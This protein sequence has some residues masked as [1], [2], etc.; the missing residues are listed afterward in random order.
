MMRSLP[1]IALAALLFAASAAAAQDTPGL[2][3]FVPE[4]ADLDTE[5]KSTGYEPSEAHLYEALP[6]SGL[7]HEIGLGAIG[8]PCAHPWR[9]KFRPAPLPRRNLPQLRKAAGSAP[10]RFCDL[11]IAKD[12][13]ARILPMEGIRPYPESWPEPQSVSIPYSVVTDEGIA[14]WRTIWT[15]DAKSDAADFRTVPPVAYRLF[16]NAELIDYSNAAKSAERT[17][18]RARFNGS[19]IE[20]RKAFGSGAGTLSTIGRFQ[21]QPNTLT[22]HILHERFLE[23]SFL[24]IL[25]DATNRLSAPVFFQ[26]ASET[27]AGIDLERA[28]VL[29]TSYLAA[30]ARTDHPLFTAKYFA[31][32]AGGKP[33]LSPWVSPTAD[34]AATAAAIRRQRE[35]GYA[36]TT[37]SPARRAP[38]SWTRYH[39]NPETNK[40]ELDPAATEAAGRASAAAFPSN[41]LNPYAVPPSEL[42]KGLATASAEDARPIADSPVV[43]ILHSRASERIR[44]YENPETPA[45]AAFAEEVLRLRPDA[46]VL[47][48][49]DVAASGIPTETKVLVVPSSTDACSPTVLGAVRQFVARGGILAAGPKALTRNEFGMVHNTPLEAPG[50]TVPG[51]HRIDGDPAAFAEAALKLVP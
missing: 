17:Y 41:W 6:D 51:I 12:S 3:W 36:F 46:T 42:L 32:L 45:P 48:E 49:K 31:A 13:H 38:R 26:P 50:A 22:A 8:I 47:L 2:V 35:L 19:N 9:R 20:F 24:H 34:S 23:E 14:L 33:V 15:E 27:P 7:A 1:S 11:A 39:K 29:C 44:A 25:E 4:G 16:E 21:D 10:I 30:P 18:Y 28:A 43:A 5:V 40:T 37:L